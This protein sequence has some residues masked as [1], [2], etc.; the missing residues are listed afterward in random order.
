MSDEG[1]HDYRDLI[2]W[3]KALALAVETYRITRRLPRDETFGLTSQI[4]RSA[5]SIPSNIAE[6]ASRRT[7]RDYLGFLYVARGSLSE[8]ETQLRIAREVELLSEADLLVTVPLTREVGRLL[9]AV[10]SG[11]HRRACS[12]R[13]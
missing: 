9:N 10:I 6:G 12:T 1:N 8:L 3:Q 2:V 11:L 4:R 7:T 13:R 5:V